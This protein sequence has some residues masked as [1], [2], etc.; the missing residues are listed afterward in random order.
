VEEKGTGVY[1]F[2]T[3]GTGLFAFRRRLNRILAYLDS[4]DRNNF[5]TRSPWLLTRVQM[6]ATLAARDT[7]AF[8]L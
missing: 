4:I 5:L 7:P 1:S 3:N 8:A 6:Y 2:G